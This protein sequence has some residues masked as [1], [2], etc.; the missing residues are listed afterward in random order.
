MQGALPLMKGFINI[1]DSSDVKYN[2][3]IEE[4]EEALKEILE[5]V[6]TEASDDV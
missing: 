2:K 4:K 1:M 6:I 3:E 5:E